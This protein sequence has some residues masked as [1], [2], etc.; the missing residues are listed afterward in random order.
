MKK[1]IIGVAAGLLALSQIAFAGSAEI[2]SDAVH[3]NTPEVKAISKSEHS[4]EVFMDLVNLGNKTHT[5]I[6]AVSPVAKE[7]QLHKTIKENGKSMMQQVNHIKVPSHKDKFLH[8][9]GMHVMLIGLKE[10]LEKGQNIPITLVFADGSDIT[11]NA[12][13]TPLQNIG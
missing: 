6:A 13:V 12:K 10:K 1:I 2:A 3:I 4:T 7:I 9:G 5:V 8:E 11:I